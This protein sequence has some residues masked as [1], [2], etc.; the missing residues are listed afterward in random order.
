MA[1]R[2]NYYFDYLVPTKGMMLS[3]R[4]HSR[5]F[6]SENEAVRDAMERQRKG[7]IIQAQIWDRTNI[8]GHKVVGSVGTSGKFRRGI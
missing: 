4:Q 3:K 1:Q 2:K 5:D 7:K 6:S 8:I